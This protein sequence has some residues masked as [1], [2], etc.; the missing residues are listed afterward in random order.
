ML[1]T[2]AQAQD[3][4]IALSGGF[5]RLDP[6]VTGNASDLNVLSQIYETLLTLDSKT[7]ELKPKLAESFEATS[8][9]VWTFHLRDGVTFSNGT[10]LTA[11][12][13]KFSIER[14][15]DPSLGSTHA[16]QLSS[17][18][19]VR[20]IDRLT[21]EIETKKPD[22]VL[23]RRM[24]PI[25]GTG[26]V[27]IVSKS[28]VEG[29]N[30][31]DVASDPIGTGPFKL[32]SWDRGRQLTLVRNETYWGDAPAVDG[33]VYT[34]IPENSTRVNALLTGEVDVIQSLPITDVE[35]VKASERA[36]VV[37]SPNGLVHVL[38]LDSRHP[39]FDDIEVRKAFVHAI[40]IKGIVEGLLGEYGRVLAVPLSPNALQFDTELAPYTYDPA[41]SKK[42]LAGKS[43]SLKTFTSDGRYV[44]D[45]DIYQIINSQ[46]KQVGFDINAQTL[47][48]GRFVNMMSQKSGGPFYITGWDFGE[49]DAS[50]MNSILSSGAAFSVTA[51]A[52]YDSLVAQAAQE[53][54]EARRT[55]LWHDI[56][57]Y[58]HD[59]YLVGA[60][61]QSSA[62][63]GFSKN[64]DWEPRF[65]EN[66]SL[67]EFH[68]V[69]K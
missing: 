63:Y 13:V 18:K 1:T 14:I 35:R 65:G 48:W 49:G 27:Y 2:T 24:Q 15:L 38:Q 23:L 62:L 31:A 36:H 6:S 8:P 61:W 16:S 25:G 53:L 9:T 54:D 58:V 51:D 60:V 52:T 66:M 12:D 40:D 42:L 4:R 26:R 10:P 47:E 30:P 37:S 34:S 50:K 56:Q 11:E 43:I 7:G 69:N 59:Q 67:S 19:E 57:T 5:D 44:G 41:L 68:F 32:A 39:P 29:R 3:V 22:P 21:V 45:R 46:L 33:A 64:L 28:H 55:K 17:I 20:A